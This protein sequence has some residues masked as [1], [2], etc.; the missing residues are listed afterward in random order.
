MSKSARKCYCPN[1]DFW[2]QIREVCR[3]SDLMDVAG[4][5][6]ESK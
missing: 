4:E 6:N 2:T 1:R 3:S 5:N